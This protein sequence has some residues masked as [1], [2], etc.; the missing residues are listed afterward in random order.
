MASSY[1]PNKSPPNISD[2]AN[3]EDYKKML[4]VWSKFTNLSKEKKGMAVFLTLK[5]ADQ[6]AVL[7]LDTEDIASENGFENVIARLD[8]LY[9][10]DETLQKYKAFE[11][12]EQMKRSS[13]TPINDFIL[14][15]EKAHHK[16]KTYGTIISDD[17]LAYRLLKAANL[18]DAD[19]KLAKGTA[20]LEFEAMKDQLRKLFSENNSFGA[21]SADRFE[22]IQF[23]ENNNENENYSYYTKSRPYR[24]RG[25]PF[26]SNRGSNGSMNSNWRQ[27]RNQQQDASK[28]STQKGNPKNEHGIVTRC[29]IC[30]STMH[31]APECPHKS[32]GVYLASEE[33][34]SQEVHEDNFYSQELMESITLYQTDLDSPSPNLVSDAF[35]C[36]LIDCGA[37]STVC[38]KAWFDVLVSSLNEN[39]KMQVKRSQKQ[40]R[41][42][43]KF[44]NEQKFPSIGQFTFPA[45]VGN[46]NIKIQTDVIESNIP[47]LFSRESLTKAKTKICFDKH[48]ITFLGEKVPL[49]LS[50]TGHYL[51]PLTTKCAMT[52][53][54]K[55]KCRLNINLVS[56]NVTK[57][58]MALKLHRQFAHCSAER[59]IKL[60]KSA[61]DPWRNDHDLFKEIEKLDDTCEICKQYKKPKPRPVVGLPSATRFNE[62]IAM[63]LKFSE[64]QIILHLIDHATRFSVATSVPNKKPE[65]IV[66]AMLSKWISVFGAPDKFLTDNGGEFVNQDLITLAESFGITI[67]TTAA[68]SPWSNGIVERHNQVIGKMVTKILADTKCNFEVALQWASNA[69]NSLANVHGFSPYQLVLG[70]N[71]KLPSVLSDRPP[72]FMTGEKTSQLLESNLKA[73]HAAREA[74]IQAESSAK[75]KRALNTNTRTYSDQVYTSGDLVYYKRQQE[76]KWRGPAKVLG[77]DGQ[78]VLLKHGGYYVRVHPCRLM[79]LNPHPIVNENETNEPTDQHEKKEE[80]KQKPTTPIVLETDSDSDEEIADTNL[81]DFDSDALQPSNHNS[82]SDTNQNDELVGE[83][84]ETQSDQHQIVEDVSQIETDVQQLNQNSQQYDDSANP[85]SESF[86]QEDINEDQQ[87][88]CLKKNDIILVNWPDKTSSAYRLNSRAGKVGKSSQNRYKDSWNVISP[89]GVSRSINLAEQV[90]SWSFIC[91]DSNEDTSDEFISDVYFQAELNQEIELAKQ[92]ELDNWKDQNVYEEVPDQGQKC[93]T[94]RWVIE[95]KEESG[96]AYTKARLVARGFEEDQNFRTDSPTCGR[97]SLRLTLMI[98]AGKKW[99]LNSIDIKSAF[100]QGHELDREVYLRPPKEMG[101]DKIWKLKKCVYGLADAPREFYLRLSSE[102][103]KLGTTSSRLDK[104]LFLWQSEGELNGILLLHVDDIL[105][106]GNKEFQEVVNGLRKAFKIRSEQSKCFTYIGLQLSQNEDYSINVNQN[107]FSHT[108]TKIKIDGQSESNDSVSEIQRTQL[109]STTGQL[110]WLAGISRPDLAFDVCQLSTRATQAQIKD[111][112]QANKVIKRAKTDQGKIIF[113]SM[114]LSKIKVIAFADASFDNLP[115]GGSQGGNVIFLTDGKSAAPIQWSSNKIKRVVRSTIAAEALALSDACD[116][117]QYLTSLLNEQ[118]LPKQRIAIECVTDNRSLFDNIHSTKPISEQGL[119]LDI[120]AIREMKDKKKMSVQWTNSRS[121]VANVMTKKG[122]SASLLLETLRTG[123]LSKY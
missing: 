49:T 98:I 34:P 32:S 41:K 47:L 82:E 50:G 103:E 71:P 26:Y 45:K 108:I 83:S 14:K 35:N 27:P 21:K 17:L 74:F 29:T 78:F 91:N 59:L 2:S 85:T 81:I 9:L 57:Q 46:R 79:H 121:N 106:G 55:A 117:A 37:S 115:N 86:S 92:N 28:S 105:Y 62:K 13:D 75:I 123:R 60:L 95:P 94:V 7:E 40:S 64:G 3:Y 11:D 10:K 70:S 104:A 87:K 90:Q 89:D 109:R 8:R 4:Q 31:W 66:K 80:T 65:S 39:E 101:T 88:H 68:E 23:S 33:D 120:A 73:L 77:Q 114:N 113:P 118:L 38:G 107:S 96:K 63:D 84:E 116:S 122:A 20:K 72:A 76:E 54:P 30:D 69:K 53:E 15:F 1:N 119:R 102:L 43:F 48:I 97:E 16:L 6:E 12:F 22:D 25:R 19:E 93:I 24:G 67:Q 44:G 61:G 42:A 99:Q 36:A 112:L 51:L 110:N 18:G 52:L 58:E 5:G 111:L 56:E 100:L